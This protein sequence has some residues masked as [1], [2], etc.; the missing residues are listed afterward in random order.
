[1]NFVKLYILLVVSA[2]FGS[3]KLNQI[4][5][6]IATYYITEKETEQEQKIAAR[7]DEWTAIFLFQI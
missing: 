4:M 6:A 5:G 3:I 2:R 7:S 1:M